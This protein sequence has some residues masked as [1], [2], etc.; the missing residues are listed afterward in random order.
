MLFFYRYICTIN[1]FYC[2]DNTKSTD[3]FL[4]FTQALK[5]AEAR[6]VLVQNLFIKRK[7]LIA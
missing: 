3:L 7:S 2:A 1:L 4:L 5:D 6:F